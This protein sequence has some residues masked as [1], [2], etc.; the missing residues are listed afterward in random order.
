MKLKYWKRVEHSAL[1]LSGI[2]KEV[3]DKWWRFYR[4]NYAERDFS[5]HV[6]EIAYILGLHFINSNYRIKLD[7][8]HKTILAFLVEESVD[9]FRFKRSNEYGGKYLSNRNMVELLNKLNKYSVCE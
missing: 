9:R 8:H 2:S 3:P 1:D 5:E 6:R 7:L 4:K